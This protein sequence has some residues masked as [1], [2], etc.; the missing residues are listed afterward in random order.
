M[1]H[2]LLFF[3]FLIP[4]YL[5]A[6]ADNS[7]TEKRCK[8]R[9][10]RD[11]LLEKSDTCFVITRAE[12]DRFFNCRCWDEAMSLYRAAKSCADANQNA[13]SEMNK[14][15]QVCRDS[16]EQELRRSEQ[17]ARRQFL[18]AAAAN[19][20]DDAQEL[21][22]QYDRSTAYRLAD[23]AGQYVAP[24]PNAE[25]LQALLDAW[26]Y[27]PPTQPGQAASGLQVPFCYQLDYDLSG[28]VQARFGKKGRLYAFAPSNSMLYSWDAESWESRLPVQIEKGLP[29]FDL[30][31]DDRTLLFY[32]DNTLL[33]WR[34][35]KD[36][37]HVKVPN[38]SRYCFSPAGDEFFFFD[39]T[40]ATIYSLDLR[41]TDMTQRDFK[42]VQRKSDKVE[43]RAEPR[44]LTNVNF[45]VLGMSYTDGRLWLAGRDSI[46]LL[47]QGSGKERQWK[48][49]KSIAWTGEMPYTVVGVHLFPARQGAWVF[50]TDS[51]HYYRLPELADSQQVAVK[52]AGVQ[53]AALAVKPDGSWFA[54]TSFEQLGVATDSST[55]H[56]GCYL[57]PGEEFR[58][59]AGAISPD[60]RWLAAATD[61]G[62]LKIW[63]LYDWQSSVAASLTGTSQ[64]VFS[65]NGNHFACFRDN[66]VEVYATDQPDRPLFSEQRQSEDVFIDAVGEN[67]IAWRSGAT[68]LTL[69]NRQNGQKWELPV[70]SSLE[71]FLPVAFDEKGRYVAYAAA[72]D[73][74]A[75]RNLQNGELVA[76]Q[77]FIG[78]ILQLRFVPGSNE[79]VVIQSVESG[80][81]AE[82]QTIAKIWNPGTAANKPH[83]VRLHGYKIGWSDI[84]PKGDQ[85][86][87]SSGQD[88]RVFRLDNLLDER[89]RIRP[90]GDHI[91][92]AL[93]FHP[94]GTALAA[95]YEDGSVVVWDLASGEVRFR[96]KVADEWIDELSFSADGNR[97]RLKTL[98]GQLFSRDISPDLIRTA[99]QNENR[100]LA[101]FTPEQ[102][103]EYD[104][105][106]ALDYSG[107]FQRLAES[108]DLPLIRSF[109]EYYRQQALRSNNIERVKAY[110]ESASNLY[111]KLEDPA[112]QQALR[113]V[114]FEIYEDYNW[115]LLLREKNTE[116][117]RVLNDFNRLFGKP[118][119][120]IKIGAHT[121]LLRNDLPA[122]ARQYADWTM[123]IY[124]KAG[125][126]SYKAMDS[127]E[128]QFQQLAEYDLLS[129]E[130]RACI[131]GI[132]SNTLNM[133]KICPAEYDVADVPFDADT[134]LRWNIFQQLY[135]S[136]N[137]LNHSKK[138][139]LLESVYSDV[140]TSFR[141]NANRWRS[142]LEKTT[143]ALA[144]AYTDWGA[145]EQGN[146][147]SEKLYKQ[148]LQ[149]LDTIGTF[150]NGEPERLKAI[151]VN[152][153]LL[154]NC[155]LNTD[156][157]GEAARQYELGLD[158]TQRVLQNAPADSLSTFR[159]DYRAP[160]LTQL[161][162][163]HL[164]EGNA[165]AAKTAYEQAYD[166]MIYGLNS[167][168][169]G[170]IALLGGNE[171][172][173]LNQY[174][175]IYSE[176][177]LGQVLFEINRMGDRLPTLKARLESFRSRLRDTILHQHAE[178][179]PEA[180]DYW[181][182]EQQTTYFF[183]NGRWKEVVAWNEKSLAAL[184]KLTARQE[185]AHQWE[186]HKLDALLARSY[187]LIYLS[188]TNPEALS[189]SIAYAQQGEDY[190]EKEYP[191]YAY[192]D[193]FKTNVAHACALRNQPGD[194][195]RAI[196]VYRDFLKETSYDFDRW[197]L[198]QKDFRDIHRGGLIW[199]DLKGIIQTIKPPNVEIS[200]DE[201]QEMGI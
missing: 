37:F 33:F 31:P 182:A 19:L 125:S 176:A 147:Y 199:P 139:A 7:A 98:A 160:L 41:S 28:N 111:S 47:E 190:A 21:L 136:S 2:F 188:K 63:A 27:L 83:P 137:I 42:N 114:M 81:Y 30:S 101:A 86:A 20:A 70:T 25:C 131:C 66:A 140:M 169:F 72:D 154:G 159:N 1:R 123:L 92:G 149:L 103:R 189:E 144:A 65:Q 151:S 175:G 121:A 186:T 43:K 50:G 58:M 89:T 23:F 9:A 91:V 170:H 120:G 156:R 11:F 59:L 171:T 181:L 34:S 87:F 46:A 200:A 105:E 93:A 197:E 48:F 130:Q 174:K 84:A 161:G 179:I 38:I 62:T 187:Y 82:S 10:R 26:Y 193:W 45:E 100:R 6:Q 163:A 71:S 153:L 106:K 146:A 78:E 54:Y 90:N 168:Y 79:L 8:C 152:R 194:R 129:S 119:T 173:A 4:V 165:A 35:P 94:D 77:N 64:L 96:L 127:L 192:R 185:I 155:L 109:F 138:A 74:V 145:F 55:D 107:N 135:T 180:A 76:G 142:Q 60:N 73:S 184:E 116:A 36:T 102:I 167:F 124:E 110:F 122:A 14:R 164:L 56:F 39:G 16:A 134:R 67:W 177:Q 17:A 133:S 115:K 195:D 3:I 5:T 178:M 51:L 108:G 128:Q 85:V 29:H 53:G 157:I 201:W 18:H 158:A 172:E 12:A 40:Q 141:Q 75:V 88:I 49:G 95:A 104:L 150:K 162:M 15:I 97:L 57:Q 117:Q 132:F 80:M 13:R 196:A 32:S 166:A 126:D 52:I 191:S 22:K 69:K 113:P 118:L 99:A 44:F 143:L 112:A 183:A 61:T 148:A 68:A 24:G 198:L